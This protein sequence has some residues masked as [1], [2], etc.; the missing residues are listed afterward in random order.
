MVSWQQGQ[1]FNTLPPL[2]FFWKKVKKRYT[3]WWYLLKFSWGD[4]GG[5]EIFSG[6]V[7]EKFLRGWNVGNGNLIL[8][9]VETSGNLL[10]GVEFFGGG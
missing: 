3:R 8:W 9:G 1:L 2:N 7:V 10:E 6:G 5:V 4:T